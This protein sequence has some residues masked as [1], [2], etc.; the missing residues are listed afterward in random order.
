MPSICRSTARHAGHLPHRWGSPR[1][2]P[3]GL[4]AGLQED[5]TPSTLRRYHINDVD[6]LRRA[7][8][9]AAVLSGSGS[10]KIRV[11]GEKPD[12][13]RTLDPISPGVAHSGTRQVRDLAGGVSGAE[14]DRTANLL[15][16]I[17]FRGC[18]SS[19]RRTTSGRTGSVF[20]EPLVPRFTA[21]GWLNPQRTRRAQKPPSPIRP[22]D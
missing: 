3:Q 20:V 6:D 10:G 8:E 17:P 9:T 11:L 22:A 19:P 16:A 12:T 13:T 14:R 15:N 21:L 18:L 5:T 1:R 7:A 2:F 4:A